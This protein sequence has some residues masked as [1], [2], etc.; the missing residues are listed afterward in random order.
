M[1]NTVKT[2]NNIQ[3]AEKYL[4]KYLSDL[5]KHFHISE[6]QISSILNN[7]LNNYKKEHVHFKYL[8]NLKNNI[9][10][11]FNNNNNMI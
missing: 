10:K 5:Q 4:E 1:K 6:S 2:Q 11:L 3:I 9:Q 7:Q 8:K